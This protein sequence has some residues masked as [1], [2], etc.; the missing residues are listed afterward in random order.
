M[1][2]Q[3]RPRTTLHRFFKPVDSST[4]VAADVHAETESPTNPTNAT[5]TAQ[6][7]ADQELPYSKVNPN[8]LPQ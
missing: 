2:S 7:E 6:V 5:A 3:K 4:L 1:K 8:S